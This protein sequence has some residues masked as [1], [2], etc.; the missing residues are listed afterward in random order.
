M[1][2]IHNKNKP[3]PSQLNTPVLSL[4]LCASKLASLRMSK[5]WKLDQA[6]VNQSMQDIFDSPGV[7]YRYSNAIKTISIFKRRIH[8]ALGPLF[9]R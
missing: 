8:N 6:A 2:E 1:V 7:W 4:E 9:C 5:N 3:A